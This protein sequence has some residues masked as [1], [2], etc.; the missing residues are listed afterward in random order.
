MQ[1]LAFPA[2]SNVC[3]G[4]TTAS[5]VG[6]QQAASGSKVGWPGPSPRAT[7]SSYYG[8]AQSIIG[9]ARE[10]VFCSVT[11]YL[12]KPIGIYAPA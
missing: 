2:A 8:C 1:A 12:F 10:P 5:G 11:L 6:K 7:G 4:S 9:Y 3:A